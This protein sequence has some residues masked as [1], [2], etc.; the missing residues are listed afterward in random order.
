MRSV[1][2]SSPPHTVLGC[3]QQL[4]RQ[5]QHRPST[6]LKTCHNATYANA[7]GGALAGMSILSHPPTPFNQSCT[8]GHICPEPATYVAVGQH[9]ASS[10]SWS[11]AVQH[12]ACSACMTLHTVPSQGFLCSIMHKREHRDPVTNTRKLISW[13]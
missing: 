4:H 9:H 7:F 2:L 8:D 1:T 10:I 6:P 11:H 12:A 3:G 5:P 13:S